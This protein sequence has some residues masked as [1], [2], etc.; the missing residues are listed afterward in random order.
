MTHRESSSR[1]QRRD[2]G[3]SSIEYA[4]L[5][6]SIAAVVIVSVALLGP[7]VMGLFGI[8]W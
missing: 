4:L 3:A 6:A 1:W 8:T 5:L 2:R 7:K